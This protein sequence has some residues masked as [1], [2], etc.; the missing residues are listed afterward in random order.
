MKIDVHA[1]YWTN[2]YLNL[3]AGLGKTDTDTQRGMGAGDGDELA[4]RFKLMDRAGVDM[5]IL[6]ACPQ[7]PYSTDRDAAVRVA[8]FVNDQYAALVMAHPGRF[9]AFVAT[10]MPDVE[11]SIAEIARGLDELGMVGVCVNTTILN[12]PLIDDAFMPIFEALDRRGAILYIHP[13]GNSCCTPLIADHHLTWQ[14]G[15]PMEDTISIM[16]LITKGIPSRY[17]NIRIINS[18]LGGAMPMLMQRA[19]KT[20]RYF[21]FNVDHKV[22]GIQYMVTSFVFLLIGF[23]MML[24]MRWQ[25][26]IPTPPDDFD[27]D[28]MGMIRSLLNWLFPENMPFGFMDPAFYNQLGAMHGTIMIFLGIVPL[29]VAAFGNYVMP[30]QIGAPDMAFPRLN[31]AS[32]WT[33]LVGGIV[34]M[35]SF[36]APGGAPQSGWTSYAPLSIVAPPGQTYWLIGMVILITSSLFGAIN[37]IVTTLNMR[38]KGLTFGR[39]PVFCWAQLVT[40]VLLLLAFPV[41]EA[42]ALL[43]LLDRVAGT[44]FYIPKDLMY[45]STVFPRAGG[46]DPILW[47]HLFWFLAH[48][49]V[50]V[51]VLPAFGIAAGFSP[52]VWKVSRCS[53]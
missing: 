46:G 5:Q 38:A 21:E 30:L 18:H 29:G 35:A 32:Y 25:L 48:P 52:T 50:Y 7:M 4:A 47:Q 16:Q 20:E 51:L 49:E 14:V 11:A 27:P 17:P 53:M 31:M 41:L 45:G 8:R 3:V 22:I 13:A 23:S 24:L 36:L 10:P 15:A 1:H 39:M 44:S 28:K 33:F 2:E 34:M 43:Q 40:A 12:K 42:G 9:R 37:F 19:D 6:S 26:A